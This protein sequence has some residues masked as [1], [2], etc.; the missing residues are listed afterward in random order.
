MASRP[1]GMAIKEIISRN[2]D[3][4]IRFLHHALQDQSQRVFQQLPLF[5]TVNVNG[6]LYS[7]FDDRDAT[8][9]IASHS[10]VRL[11][12]PA[13]MHIDC[14]AD[15]GGVRIASMAAVEGALLG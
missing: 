1:P 2:S 5:S 3:L 7:E 6:W 14:A 13:G 9:R 10:Q 4:L 8:N 15:S 12:P 11:T